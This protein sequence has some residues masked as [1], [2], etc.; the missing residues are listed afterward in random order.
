M[1]DTSGSEFMAGFETAC[2]QRGIRLFV[3]APHSPK[4]NGCVERAN[5]THVKNSVSATTATST[6]PPR[7]QPC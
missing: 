2:Q 3:L 1:R 7:K 5:R 6:Y 4:L